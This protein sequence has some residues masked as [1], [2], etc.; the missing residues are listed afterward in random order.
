MSYAL[1]TSLYF[2]EGANADLTT[3]GARELL[4]IATPL[5][6]LIPA[7]VQ[8]G[9]D[10]VLTGNPGD[11]KSHLIRTLQDRGVLD[12]ADVVPDLSARSTEEVVAEWS[13]ARAAGRRFVLGANEGPLA[14][15][16]ERMQGVPELA[17]VRADLA[18]QLGHLLVDR[19]EALPRE[20]S[21]AL[22]VDLADRNVLEP[23]LI[24]QAL[25]RVAR[26]EFLPDLG[27]TATET[28]A[29]RNLLLFA[30]SAEARR[31]LAACLAVAGQRTSE[32]VTF[33]M[34]WGT[35][36]FAITANKKT[37]TLRAELSRDEVGLGTTPLDNLAKVGVRGAGKGHL[38]EAV[39]AFADPAAYSDPELDEEL[40]ATGKPA[41][42]RWLVDDP[43]LVDAPARLWSADP[44]AALE[45]YAQLKRFVALAHE[46]G[47]RLVSGLLRGIDLPGRHRDH[48]LRGILVKGLRALFISPAEEGAAPQWLREGLPLWIGFSYDDGPVEE[49]PH[50]AVQSLPEDE[51]EV[52][53]PVR[54]PWLVEA[55]G[56]LPEVAWL[57]HRPSGISLRVE[58]DLLAALRAACHTSGPARVPEPVQRFLSRLSGW[59]ERSPPSS[60]GR[61]QM[62]VL[63]CPRG[64]I[65]VFAAIQ[66]YDDGGAGYA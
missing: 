66:Q 25:R 44:S 18:S 55:L 10:V 64:R 19:Q 4:H 21:S 12:R 20:P 16:L 43:P 11:G 29:G 58:A 60:L 56:P 46:A 50:V 6:A 7:Q 37:T 24:E 47:E 15:L 17:Q 59:A 54:A 13:M 57:A 2:G 34:L 49:R 32:H 41:A 28:S 63:R 65:E 39:R 1:L 35:I 5:E 45:R 52:H 31:R 38:V 8:R 3:R 22:L 27:P 61:E 40:W 14:G 33:R 62:A 53:R 30:E 26:E 23:G 48:A 36:A 42:G 9:L 51:F